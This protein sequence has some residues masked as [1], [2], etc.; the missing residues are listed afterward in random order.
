MTGRPRGVVQPASRWTV[1]PRGRRCPPRHRA[2]QG[3]PLV[4]DDVVE[5]QQ[6]SS[7]SLGLAVGCNRVGEAEGAW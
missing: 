6:A 5:V 1:V 4:D 3:I 2:R 7:I